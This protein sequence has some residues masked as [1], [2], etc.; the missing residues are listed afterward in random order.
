MPTHTHTLS[1]SEETKA[2]ILRIQ[3]EAAEK[4]ARE[5]A[6]E[7]A[8]LMAQKSAWQPAPEPE[9]VMEPGKRRL[10]DLPPDV[11]RPLE[12]YQYSLKCRGTVSPLEMSH[13]LDLHPDDLDALAATAGSL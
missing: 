10:Y 3:T 6:K 4:A 1:V 12:S 2:L 7:E 8:A 9:K 13:L 11:R 5:R